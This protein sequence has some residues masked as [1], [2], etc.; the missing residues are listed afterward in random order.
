MEILI[1]GMVRRLGSKTTLQLLAYQIHP[2]QLTLQEML[3]QLRYK[4][5]T[6]V[7]MPPL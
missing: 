6:S 5:L 2:Q 4:N 7:M 1:S 3:S